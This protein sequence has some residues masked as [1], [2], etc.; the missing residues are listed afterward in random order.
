[1]TR[2]WW[3][4]FPSVRADAPRLQLRRWT[5]LDDSEWEVAFA[6][7]WTVEACLEGR[8]FKLPF[9]LLVRVGAIRIRGEM[10]VSFPNGDMG[11]T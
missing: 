1:M 11:Q 3:A 5:S 9:K 2:G 10:V 6:P 7:C 8:Q 4:Q